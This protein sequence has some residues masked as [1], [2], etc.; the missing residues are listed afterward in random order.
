MSAATSPSLSPSLPA[1]DLGS[2]QPVAQKYGWI[3]KLSKR[4]AK[5]RHRARVAVAFG[6]K[7]KRRFFL[8]HD[9]ILYYYGSDDASL[10]P[11]GGVDL[12]EYHSCTRDLDKF[13]D[14]NCIRI[15]SMGKHSTVYL[16]FETKELMDDWV[17]ALRSCLATPDD[18]QKMAVAFLNQLEQ[19]SA[20]PT[21]KDAAVSAVPEV[22]QRA[23]SMDSK[24]SSIMSRS[25]L[26]TRLATI[27]RSLKKQLTRSPGRATEASTDDSDSLS[28][29]AGTNSDAGSS[30]I[31]GSDLPPTRNNTAVTVESDVPAK[32]IG[33]GE[34]KPQSAEPQAELK[35]SPTTRSETPT[36]NPPTTRSPERT[37]RASTAM[38]PTSPVYSVVQADAVHSNVPE[39]K[40]IWFSNSVMAFTAVLIILAALLIQFLM[41]PDQV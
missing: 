37:P 32:E 26:R 27:K 41:R 15:I 10:L 29:D 31:A 8:L 12:R 13:V 24:R 14:K 1:L 40:P 4:A 7:W 19:R 3:D 21:A 34:E 18:Q 36:I 11:K 39:T 33:S 20:S 16:A 22:E 30:S 9:R 35:R 38:P 6:G 17:G 28:S 5:G 25:S 23:E 2:L